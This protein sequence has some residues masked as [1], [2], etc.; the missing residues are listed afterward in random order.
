MDQDLRITT[1]PLSTPRIEPRGDRRGGGEAFARH[2]DGEEEA[3]V[4]ETEDEPAERGDRSVAGPEDDEAGRRLDV[5][6]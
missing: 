5:T 6:G 2:I 1:G 4:E 3:Q